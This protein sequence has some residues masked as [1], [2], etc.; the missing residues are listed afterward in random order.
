MKRV[1]YFLPPL[2][3]F[4]WRLSSLAKIFAIESYSDAIR[5]TSVP[6]QIPLE[7]NQTA[8]LVDC[9]S[10]AYKLWKYIIIFSKHNF[11]L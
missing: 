8:F 2:K 6:S 9:E 5:F 7:N 4:H 3:R 1:I 11:A 10:I